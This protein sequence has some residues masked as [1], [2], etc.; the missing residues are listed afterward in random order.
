MNNFDRLL[1]VWILQCVVSLVAM[2]V[3]VDFAS[4][5]FMVTSIIVFLLAMMEGG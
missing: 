4:I 5:T 2:L 3:S 1:I